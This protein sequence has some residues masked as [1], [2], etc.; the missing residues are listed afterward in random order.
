MGIGTDGGEAN[1]DPKAF[2]VEVLTFVLVA[3]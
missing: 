2:K 1:E 3:R